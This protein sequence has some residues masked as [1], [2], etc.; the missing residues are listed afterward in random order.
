MKDK[1]FVKIYALEKRS[2]NQVIF[3]SENSPKDIYNE[4]K[5]SLV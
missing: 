1:D 2:E 3:S 5:R 4:I